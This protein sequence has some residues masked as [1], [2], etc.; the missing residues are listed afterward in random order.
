MKITLINA[1]EREESSYH[2]AKIFLEKFG[3]EHTLTEIFL[4]RDFGC[5]CKG[6]AACVVKGEQLCPHYD[7]LS[8]A[9]DAVDGADLLLFVTPV[10]VMRTTGQMKALLD[11][12]AYRYIIHRPE[13]KMFHKTAVVFATGAGGGM[14]SAIKDI[15]TSLFYWGVPKSYRFGAAT[16]SITWAGVSGQKKE[17]FKKRLARLAKKVNKRCQKRHQPPIL[18]KGLFYVMRLVH[19]KDESADGVYWGEKGWTKSLRPWKTE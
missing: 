2:L 19:T 16:A 3:G 14:K 5:F 6:C 10:F 9:R 12:F 8:K 15:T 7:A 1:T 18:T 4:P 13:E 11:H 17:A